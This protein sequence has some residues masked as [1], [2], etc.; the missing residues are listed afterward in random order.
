MA[1]RPLG[2]TQH[3]DIGTQHCPAKFAK[4]FILARRPRWLT[5]FRLQFGE[6]LPPP[7]WSFSCHVGLCPH[8]HSCV[9]P[10]SACNAEHCSAASSG[11]PSLCGARRGCPAV[12]VLAPAVGGLDWFRRVVSACMKMKQKKCHISVHGNGSSVYQPFVFSHLLTRCQHS[13]H[14]FGRGV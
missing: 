1:P 7:E 11:A 6:I 13:S 3:T 2:S 8:A 5:A 10:L 12:V 4:E 14:S 9:D